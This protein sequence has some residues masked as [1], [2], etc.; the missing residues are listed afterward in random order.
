MEAGIEL[1]AI[2]DHE[3]ASGYIELKDKIPDELRL[4]FGVEFSTHRPEKPEDK[5]EVDAGGKP[6]SLRETHIL[7]YFPGGVTGSLQ[8]CLQELQQERINRAKVALVNLRKNG[9]KLTYSQLME[10]VH[11]N[12]ISRAHMAR[13]LIANGLVSSTYDAFNRYLDVSRGIVP[14]PLL[15]PKRAIS[16]ITSEG[17]IPVWAHP[18][19]GAFDQ[20]VKEYVEYGL[21]G[22]EI[23]SHRRTEAYSF[24]FE[25]T[26]RVLGLMVTYG[27]DWH[28]FRDEKL[29][30]TTVPRESVADFLDAFQR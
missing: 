24:Y 30:C 1:A 4:L 11:G 2:T 8:A 7:G 17:G 20:L 16:L 28:G 23:C 6:V 25:R 22:V 10:H 9:C 5:K 13:A 12:C 21:R 15:T 19:L 27:S 14:P 3:T 26:A 18:E 29:K